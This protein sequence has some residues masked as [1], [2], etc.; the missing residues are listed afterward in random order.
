MKKSI[1]NMALTSTMFVFLANSTFA[2]TTPFPSTQL[3]PNDM[4]KIGN[5]MDNAFKDLDKLGI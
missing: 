1:L 5:Q 2:G 4:A 3:N